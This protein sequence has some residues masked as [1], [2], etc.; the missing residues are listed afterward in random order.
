MLTLFALLS[1]LGSGSLLAERP[2][3]AASETPA[4]RSASG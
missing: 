1:T 2:T 4:L 3:A